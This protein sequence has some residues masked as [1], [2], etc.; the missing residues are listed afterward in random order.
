[1]RQAAE[2]ALQLTPGLPESRVAMSVYYRTV[3]KDPARSLEQCRQGLTASPNHP[4]LLVNAAIAE[5]NLGRSQEALL[6]LEQ[7]RSL[8]PRSVS[9]ARRIGV[10]LLYLRRYRDAVAAFDRALILSPGSLL[11]ID[12][13]TM[14]YLAQG[15]LAAARSFLASAGR[16][17]EPTALVAYLATYYD[18]VWVLAS[19][20]TLLSATRSSRIRENN[21]PP[22][23]RFLLINMDHSI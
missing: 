2:R 3:V 15:D 1:V 22:I 11:I 13:K 18:L 23:R 10:S 14:A 19:P 9:A 4:E 12:L 8:D 20:E 16:N 17:V 6:H 21:L 7:A 5:Q